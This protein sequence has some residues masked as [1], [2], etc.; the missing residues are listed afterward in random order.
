MK[1]DFFDK[2]FDELIEEAATMCL[3]N[4]EI[5]TGEVEKVEFS[6]LHKKKME[7]LFKEAKRADIRKKAVRLTKK[8]AVVI[9]CAMLITTVLITSVRAWRE[10]VVKFIMKNND[11]NYMSIKFGD[12]R[13]DEYGEKIESGDTNK[14]EPFV[15]DDM[16]FLYLPEGFEFEKKE[17]TGRTTYYRFLNNDNKFVKIKKEQFLNDL[18]KDSDVEES[19]NEKIKFKD[20]EVFKVT[21][22]GV[23]IMYIWYGE[24]EIYNVTSNI[25][26]KETLKFIENIKNLKNF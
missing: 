25:E 5:N 21:K 1:K 23:R 3:E 2:I 19:Y 6:D 16:K 18:G 15:I 8:V 13:Y 7:K 26:E 17:I 22:E 11:D 24:R 14:S 20:K 9:L 12:T 10:E 4:E